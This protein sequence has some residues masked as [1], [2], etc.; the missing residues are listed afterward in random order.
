MDDFIGVKIALIKDDELLVIQRDNKP[1][2]AYPGLWDFAGGSREENE[3]PFECASREVYE[4]LGIKLHE[5]SIIWQRVYPA[6]H[7]P[8]LIAHFMVAPVTN[9]QLK[10]IVFGDE[11]QGWKMISISE[12]LDS[13]EVVEPLKGRLTDYLESAVE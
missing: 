2:L 9:E 7:D 8:S 10:G 6:M 1:N 3:T 12:F 4:E 11:G 13:D 5:R